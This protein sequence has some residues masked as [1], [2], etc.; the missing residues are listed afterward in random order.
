M[1]KRLVLV[2]SVCLTALLISSCGGGGSS[3][4]T[5][6]GLWSVSNK[7]GVT[8]YNPDEE[9]RTATNHQCKWYCALYEGKKQYVSVAWSTL[10]DDPVNDWELYSKSTAGCST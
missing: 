3:S 9:R 2:A 10:Y 7:S 1:I 6:N 4:G 5:S 8:C